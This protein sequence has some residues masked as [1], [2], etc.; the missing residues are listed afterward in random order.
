MIENL[1]HL[2]ETWQSNS[3]F[4]LV[5]ELLQEAPSDLRP[6]LSKLPEKFMGT[7]LAQVEKHNKRCLR[8]K[9]L[10]KAALGEPE[11][12]KFVARLLLGQSLVDDLGNIVVEDTDSLEPFQSPIHGTA[13][14]IIKW[15]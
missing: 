11:T 14:D 10:L 5:R 2:R 15:I 3:S 1:K 8:T 13:I 6:V 9:L 7:A 12:G 4:G